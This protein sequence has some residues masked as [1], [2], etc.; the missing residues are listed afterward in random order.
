MN[1]FII[2][3]PVPPEELIDREQELGRLLELALGGHN[4]RLSAP[5]RYGKT[6]LLERMRVEADKA[7][8]ATVY[9]D[10]FGV[11]SLG[12]LAQRIDLAYHASLKGPAA[13]WFA[14]VRRRWVVRIRGGLTGTGGEIE[15]LPPEQAETL[16]GELLDLPREI[17]RRDGTQ[18]IV[19]FDEFQEVLSASDRA[20]AVIRSTIQHHRHEAAYVFAGSHPGLMRELFGASER[21]LYGQARPVELDRLADEP[22][23]A[24]VASRFDATGRE[25]GAAADPLL[26][27]AR[28]HPQR[29]MLLAH[30]LWEATPA[31]QTA[32][33]DR[34]ERASAAALRDLQETF[35]RAWERL[36]VSERRT[37][38]AVA[39]IGPWGGG[40][41]LYGADTLS[42]FRLAKSTA[43]DLATTLQRR[44]ELHARRDG[45]G[46]ELVDPLFEVWIASE[47]RARR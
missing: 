13:R 47:R 20:D 34:W 31:G 14:G 3:S 45:T 6:T 19:Q 8:A 24:Y 46:L 42:R 30:Y 37:L 15:S 22:L 43:Q 11:V 10:C 38:A 40:S 18:T 5:R 44:G 29:A 4:A 33:I 16:L 39:W 9:V 36:S 1:P 2:D 35:E 26:D 17:H 41:T 21:P 28:G 7:G 23:L 25:L 27:L 32:D 12:E